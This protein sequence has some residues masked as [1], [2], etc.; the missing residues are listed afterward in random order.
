MIVRHPSVFDGKIRAWNVI[1]QG[2]DTL[3][4][5]RFG[6]SRSTWPIW[7]KDGI[8]YETPSP[9]HEYENPS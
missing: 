3:N 8:I 9:F 4:K 1:L 2:W 7:E 5:V 6:L